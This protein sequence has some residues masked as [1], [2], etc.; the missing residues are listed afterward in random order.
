M[1]KKVLVLLMFVFSFSFAWEPATEG[2]GNGL[3][4][5]K[6]QADATDILPI[7]K[8]NL[9]AEQ[10]VIVMTTDPSGALGNN[11]KLFPD[12]NK[13]KIGYMQNF[14]ITSMSTL[15]KIMTNDPNGM[16][17]SPFV[18]T[19]YQRDGDEY[20]YIIRT[21]PSILVDGTKYPEVKKAVEEFEARVDKAIKQLM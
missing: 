3:V 2:S 4:I 14:L 1:F 17:L 5:Y 13:F 6:I 8:A 10:I 12:Y 16:V 9:E 18:I 21:K 11:V 19:V 20:S 15:Y 7:L